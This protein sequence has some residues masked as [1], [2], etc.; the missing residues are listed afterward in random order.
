[1]LSQLLLLVDLI[2]FVS[3]Q[4]QVILRHPIQVELMFGMFLGEP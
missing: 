3:I 4:V 1:M 2:W